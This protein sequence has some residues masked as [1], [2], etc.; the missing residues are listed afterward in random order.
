MPDAETSAAPAPPT[1]SIPPP[2]GIARTTGPVSGA[3]GLPLLTT[4]TAMKTAMRIAAQP[5]AG[6]RTAGNVMRSLRPLC[7][8]PA[9]PTPR[10]MRACSP[11]GSRCSVADAA[12][13]SRATPSQ[14]AVKPRQSGQPARCRRTEPPT[15]RPES[16]ALDI[17]HLNHAHLSM[18]HHLPQTPDPQADAA[19][20][21]ASNPLPVSPTARQT[22]RPWHDA[23]PPLRR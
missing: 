5:V 17:R 11:G 6:A 22:S 3:E 18:R 13:N 10:A 7:A 14:R 21:A 1:T 12:L 4:R 15:C 16:I 8:A 9:C 19:R 23:T 2:D 20:P